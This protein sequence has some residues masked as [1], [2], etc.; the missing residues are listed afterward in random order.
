MQLKISSK[1]VSTIILYSRGVVC[2]FTKLWTAAS[3]FIRLPAILMSLTVIPFCRGE[4]SA[5]IC[6]MSFSIGTLPLL[7]L[8][9]RASLLSLLLATASLKGTIRKSKSVWKEFRKSGL[10][11]SNAWFIK[12]KT[13]FTLS[14]WIYYEF[15]HKFL[16]EFA[17]WLTNLPQKFLKWCQNDNIKYVLNFM[18]KKLQWVIISLSGN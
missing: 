7:T 14:L 9:L 2:I 11:L 10:H 4:Y 15:Y 12:F 6:P 3:T 16:E 5:L 8:Q 17:I 1:E 18:H 13:N